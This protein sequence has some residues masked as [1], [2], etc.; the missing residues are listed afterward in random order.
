MCFRI[1]DEKLL[2]NSKNIQTKIKNFKNI[3]LNA[4][5][6]YMI[7]VRALYTNQQSIKNVI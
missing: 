5:P 6:V 7:D 2:E 1:D 3:E 4:L